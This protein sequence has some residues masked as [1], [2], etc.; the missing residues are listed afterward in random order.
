MVPLNAIHPIRGKI[1]LNEWRAR[2]TTFCGMVK[3]ITAV[4]LVLLIGNPLCC[5]AAGAPRVA[6][7]PADSLPSCCQAKLDQ[8]S[9]PERDGRDSFPCPCTKFVGMVSG[10]RGYFT[11]LAALDPFPALREARTDYRIS[12]HDEVIAG[13]IRSGPPVSDLPFVPFSI[14]Y[15]V[16]RC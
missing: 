15:G 12:R 5:C 16:F 9:A 2:E 1:T 13:M 3:G 8:D 14:L 4:F 10:E 11:T 6:D 7:F